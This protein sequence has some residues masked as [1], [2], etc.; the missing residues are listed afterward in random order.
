MPDHLVDQVAATLI[1]FGG[2][3]DLADLPDLTAG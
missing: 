3:A 1:G 2:L